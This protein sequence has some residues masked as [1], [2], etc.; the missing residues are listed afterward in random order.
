MD[1]QKLQAR[2]YLE[3]QIQ[4][5]SPAQQIVMLY[6]GAIKFILQARQAI[7]AKDIQ[8]RCNANQ[9]AMEII[10][11]LLQILDIEK[12]EEIAARLHRIYAHVFQLLMKI[13][14]ENSTAAADEA[15]EHLKMLRTA[16]KELAEKGLQPDPKSAPPAS[17]TTR[18]NKEAGGQQNQTDQVLPAKRSAL[19]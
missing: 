12:G 9:R 6:D 4:N 18:P 19:A 1:Q 10:A 17:S 13:D 3:K 5:A 15:V 7:E 14:I 16:W 8:A 11:Y 2:Q